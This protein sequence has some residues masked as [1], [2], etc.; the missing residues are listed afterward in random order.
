MTTVETMHDDTPDDVIDKV[1]K[2]LAAHGLQFVDDGKEHEGMVVYNLRRRY[3]C[4]RCGGIG[5][6]PSGIWNAATKQRDSIAGV[7]DTCNGA[8]YLGF[9]ER[10]E[11]KK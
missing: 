6:Q 2:A 5:T 4:E 8:G 7:C 1:N 10:Y 9:V 11:E 3:L